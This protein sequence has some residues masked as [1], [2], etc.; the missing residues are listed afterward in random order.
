MLDKR[1]LKRKRFIRV[2]FWLELFLEKKKYL[3]RE[4]SALWL[5]NQNHYPT[6]WWV[7]FHL[8]INF[9][10]AL[11]PHFGYIFRILIQFISF[12]SPFSS[13]CFVLFC[14]LQQTWSICHAVTPPITR[15]ANAKLATNAKICTANSACQYHPPPPPPPSDPRRWAQ[16]RHSLSAHSAR[17]CFLFSFLFSKFLVGVWTH[18]SQDSREWKPLENTKTRPQ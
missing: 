9:V 11:N 15:C 6:N 18:E 8:E 10:H 1:L 17:D 13:H 2:K 4:M 3:R 14:F 16:V 7:I 5:S 12:N